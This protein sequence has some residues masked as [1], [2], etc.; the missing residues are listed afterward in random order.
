[1]A[2]L[3]GT[4]RPRKSNNSKGKHSGNAAECSECPPNPPNDADLPLAVRMH[5]LKQSQTARKGS[6]GGTSSLGNP[7]AAPS[8]YAAE[9]AASG[10]GLRQSAWG[11]AK[12]GG[13]AS[14]DLSNPRF[15]QPRGDG[16][17]FMNRLVSPSGYQH[18]PHGQVQ[19]AAVGDGYQQHADPWSLHENAADAASWPQ[20]MAQ[21]SIPRQLEAGV[22]PET[23]EPG[24]NVVKNETADQSSPSFFDMDASGRLV[25]PG[26]ST[27]HLLGLDQQGTDLK[28]ALKLPTAAEARVSMVWMSTA[29]LTNIHT[30]NVVSI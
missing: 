11:V 6:G 1:M 16:Q 28:A 19:Q 5:Q 24:P 7:N 10:A 29:A 30:K 13:S 20:P 21:Q 18:S 15:G 12:H 8:G 9:A 2:L 3:A 26:C 25:F 14:T 22:T 4:K 27:S 23:A 17:R